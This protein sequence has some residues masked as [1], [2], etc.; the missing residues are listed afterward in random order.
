MGLRAFE[1]G[2]CTARA[3]CGATRWSRKDTQTVCH[4]TIIKHIFFSSYGSSSSQ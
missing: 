1:K 2:C 4:S 3:S